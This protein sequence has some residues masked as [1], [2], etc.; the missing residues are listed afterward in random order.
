VVAAVGNH[1]RHHHERHLQ[2]RFDNSARVNPPTV[3]RLTAVGCAEI[4][5]VTPFTCRSVSSLIPLLDIR[6]QHRVMRQGQCQT[7]Q[8]AAAA[9]RVC[10]LPST[11][12]WAVG[13]LGS[14]NSMHVSSRHIQGTTPP[15]W[16]KTPATECLHPTQAS[17]TGL[18]SKL[19]LVEHNGA[20]GSRERMK[21]NL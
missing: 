11:S 8:S 21:G 7:M 9:A 19:R 5:V 1:G 20:D 15:T 18:H 6:T 17:I 14:I 16:S 13:V 4:N 10:Q 3:L 2:M 12:W